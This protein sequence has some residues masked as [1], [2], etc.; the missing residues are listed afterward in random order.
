[1]QILSIAQKGK[2]IPSRNPLIEAM[3][4]TELN[5]GVLASAQDAD[6]IAVPDCGR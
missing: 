5:T 1:M 3:F 6:R 4:M 2:S